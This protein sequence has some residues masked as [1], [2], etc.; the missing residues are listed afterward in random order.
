MSESLAEGYEAAMGPVRSGDMSREALTKAFEA[1]MACLD[2]AAAE[3]ERNALG[4]FELRE[5]TDENARSI[6]KIEA[7]AMK[8]V[9]EVVLEG[10]RSNEQERRAE[11]LTLLAQNHEWQHLI[12]VRDDY[13][14]NAAT[15]SITHARLSSTATLWRYRIEWLIALQ[16]DSS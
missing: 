14:R 10:K 13:R 5:M 4:Q 9:V 16:R 15:D 2:F 3:T 1:A 8:S 12:T 6:A 7:T 11:Q